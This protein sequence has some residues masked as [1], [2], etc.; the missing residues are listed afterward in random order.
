MIGGLALKGDNKVQGNWGEVILERLLEESGLQ[1]GREYHTQVNL[2]D[3][4]GRRKQPDII[5]HL[6]ESRDL[7]IDSKVSLS[8]YEA[9]F[10]T[11]GNTNVAVGRRRSRETATMFPRGVRT[12]LGPRDQSRRALACLRRRSRSSVGPLDDGQQCLPSRLA[13]YERKKSLARLH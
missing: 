6:P 9:F 8:S 2:T 12:R 4:Q 1:K 5:V 10:N 7:V 3:E 13:P 11:T